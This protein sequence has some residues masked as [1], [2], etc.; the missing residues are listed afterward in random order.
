V[1]AGR[2]VSA[3]AAALREAPSLGTAP[4]IL[5]SDKGCP[6]AHRVLAL[7]DHLGRA[8]ERREALVGDEPEGI[9]R[10][11]ASGRIPLLVHGN[12]VIS[13]SRVMLE[14]LA[15]HYA[16]GD[17][18]PADL[19]VRTLHRCALA[20]VDDFLAPVLMGRPFTDS[21]RARLDD[22]LDALEAAVATT[23]PRPSL[24]AF[25]VA[26]IWLR[27]RWWHPD[28]AVTG[29]IEARPSLC[30]WLDAAVRLDA[31]A[32]TAPERASD[33]TQLA[34]ARSAGLV[35]ADFAIGAHERITEEHDEAD[36]EGQR[37]CAIRSAA[38]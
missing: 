15:E 38:G 2:V 17:A 6:F 33:R 13:E 36:D 16:F 18:L 10:Y 4:P 21:D 34:R 5:F 25:H 8:P 37:S 31:V 1:S 20:V 29:A 19:A 27:F 9:G 3:A 30:A 23:V 28:G 35:P 7:L 26:P 14:H 32:R 12:V 22:V 24:L 11:S